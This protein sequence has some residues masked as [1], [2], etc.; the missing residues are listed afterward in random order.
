MNHIKASKPIHYRLLS[1]SNSMQIFAISHS[2]ANLNLI[3][4]KFIYEHTSA[5]CTSLW[6]NLRLLTECFI[7]VGSAMFGAI[8]NLVRHG[9][10]IRPRLPTASPTNRPQ[11]KVIIAKVIL[12]LKLRP[13]AGFEAK[14]V[15]ELSTRPLH[16]LDYHTFWNTDKW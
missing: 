15:A 6:W 8:F 11:P 4:A 3:T 2:T 5:T 9:S 12:K 13:A 1:F 16:V 14:V 10:Q 7:V